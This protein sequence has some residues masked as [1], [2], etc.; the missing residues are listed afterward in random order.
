MVDTCSSYRSKK[1]WST[2]EKTFLTV[3]VQWKE[4]A[5]YVGFAASVGCEGSST[6]F[7]DVMLYKQPFLSCTNSPS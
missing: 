7:C 4:H 6:S 3:F 1:S 5:V 2:E